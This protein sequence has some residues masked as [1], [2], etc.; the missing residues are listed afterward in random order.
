MLAAVN[1]TSILYHVIRN[2]YGRSINHSFRRLVDDGDRSWFCALLARQVD[3]HL[4]VNFSDAFPPAVDVTGDPAGGPPSAAASPRRGGG[5]A[6][7]TAEA[8]ALRRVV[9]APFAKAAGGEVSVL[10]RA[11]LAGWAEL[12]PGQRTSSWGLD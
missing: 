5:V 3:D 8:A 6:E 2:A 12:I 10:T 4:G 7:G 1:S 9:Y 11:L